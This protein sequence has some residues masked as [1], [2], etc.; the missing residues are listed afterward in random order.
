MKKPIHIYIDVDNT[1]YNS[2]KVVTMKLNEKY[3]MNIDYEEIR[4]Y[5][6]KDKFPMTD[7]D[8]IKRIF[9][10]PLFYMYK[11][12]D[13]PSAFSYI[14]FLYTYS[15]C[16]INFVTI[17][18]KINL[19]NKRKWLDEVFDKMNIDY[20]EFYGNYNEDNDK[21]FVDMSGGIFI[22]D[23]IEC[24]RK[25]NANIKI[26]LKNNT[27]NEWNKVL[28][29]DEIYIANDWDDVYEIIKFFCDN[30]EMI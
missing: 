18:T 21:R 12:M 7:G 1:I 4:G 30:G 6:F 15:N 8:E 13:M 2:I 16:K 23:N 17:G 28:P 26:L 22:D 10:D 19:I 24:L 9:D 14:L 11:D 20:N 25:S 3:N 5:N 27:D 29:N